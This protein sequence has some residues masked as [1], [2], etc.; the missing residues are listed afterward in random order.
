[1]QDASSNRSAD[2]IAVIIPCYNYGHFLDAAIRSV[3]AQSMVPREIVVVDDGSKD[4]TR[5]VCCRYP[6]VTYVYQVNR[7]LPGARN[8]GI[9]SSV[10]PY[11]LFLDADD[12]LEDS[13]LEC[14]L[15]AFQ[16][17]AVPVGA[18]FGDGAVTDGVNPSVKTLPDADDVSEYVESWTPDQRIAILSR[19]FLERTVCGNIIPACCTLIRREVLEDVGYWNEVY[20][21]H[22]DRDFWMRVLSS[23]QV[24]WL[25]EEVATIRK[26][27][28]NITHSGNWKRN[29]TAILQI[30]N[31]TSRADW[32]TP[33]LRQLARWQ[34]AK[35][36]Y[37]LAQR[38]ADD[39]EIALAIRWMFKSLEKR[40]LHLKAWCHLLHY[41]LRTLM[42]A[43]TRQ[44]RG[45]LP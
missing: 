38:H 43:S 23:Y 5:E 15:N 42:R 17:V 13:A 36:A 11:V 28:D 20:R 24:A 25:H 6:T 40:P 21:Y 14:L 41:G 12:I 30:L 37:S 9:R 10:S 19:S 27:E 4:N 22:E 8:T 39:S 7:G 29:H 26:H 1:M 18:V 3:L 32:A 35:E 16:T 2:G 33:K 34:F 44:P 45:Q 31:D